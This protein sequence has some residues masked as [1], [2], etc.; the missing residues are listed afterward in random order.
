MILYLIYFNILLSEQGYPYSVVVF[1]CGCMM[2]DI[3]L[4]YLNSI[5]QFVVDVEQGDPY[6]LIKKIK[7]LTCIKI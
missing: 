1:L 7:K 4:I 6:S 3:Y 2:C 5:Y